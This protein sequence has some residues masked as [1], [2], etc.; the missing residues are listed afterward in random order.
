MKENKMIQPI[1]KLYNKRLPTAIRFMLLF[2]ALLIVFLDQISKCIVRHELTFA[3]PVPFLKN[4]L[5]WTLFYN[6][7]AAFSF[8]ASQNGWQGVLFGFVAAIV[9]IFL[10]FYILNRVYS[11]LSGF[12]MAFV[13]GGAIGNLIDRFMMGKVT[14]FIDLY[15]DIHHFPIFNIA[16][17]FINIGVILII[18]DA[19]FLKKSDL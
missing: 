7:G 11:L 6:K 3:Q 16:D 19:V 1:D 18:I 17:V 4:Y 2:C 10:V 12:G 14:D 5:N 8:L 13:L 15:Y 9:V